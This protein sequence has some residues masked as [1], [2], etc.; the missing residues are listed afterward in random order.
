MVGPTRAR[1]PGTSG[2]QGIRQRL[3]LLV[4]QW[5]LRVDPVAD[6]EEGEAVRVQREPGCLTRHVGRHDWRRR[7]DADAPPRSAVGR[8]VALV[9]RGGFAL[10]E[11]RVHV[12][13]PR[14][15]EVGG[16]VEDNPEI[17]RVADHAARSQDLGGLGDRRLH[18]GREAAPGGVSASHQEE[19][20]AAGDE[21]TVDAGDVAEDLA[22]VTLTLCLPEKVRPALLPGHHGWRHE[23]AGLETP[24]VLRLV[25]ELDRDVARAQAQLE[26]GDQRGRHRVL[27]WDR[28]RIDE[29]EGA[30]THPFVNRLRT[31]D[32]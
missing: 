2:I 10:R 32:P 28:P 9:H 27:E 21:A 29:V 30:T 24:K 7:P 18:P 26:A 15:V 25:H 19:L 6:V 12:G 14:A 22:V 20:V 23:L 13:V 1:E 4:T 31:M 5:L 16:E 8:D 17:R 11:V 3:N